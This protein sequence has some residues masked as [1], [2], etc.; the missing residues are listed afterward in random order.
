MGVSPLRLALPW[1]AVVP[2]D[3]VAIV[4]TSG[5]VDPAI[6][7]RAISRL[8]AEGFVPVVGRSLKSVLDRPSS[9]DVQSFLS[10]PDAKRADDLQWALCSPEI[11]AVWA[12]RGGYG[13]QRIVDALDWAAVTEARP[14]PVLGFSD[15]TALHAALRV[16]VGWPSIQSVNL[17]G[18]LGAEAAD[19]VSV[20]SALAMLREL[21]VPSDLLSVDGSYRLL[22]DGPRPDV[23]SAPMFGGNLT[24]LATSI[25]TVEGIPPDQPFIALLE[26]VTEAPYRLDR[27]LT[28][29]VRSGWFQHAKAIV[30]GT[31]FECGPPGAAE[32][33]VVERLAH[34]GVP[35]ATTTAFGHSG[36]HLAIPHNVVLTLNVVTGHLL[37]GRTS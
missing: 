7:G 32:A 5:P 25:G 22:L 16:R 12:A 6:M 15:V 18:G 17:Q 10:A 34:L 29:L 11:S 19:E 13:M 9:A 20:S 36:R 31:F 8:T 23:I 33:V 37:P 2:R 1:P 35:I 28:Q 27:S 4:A 30:C 26:D 24:L 21:T 3:Q 14:R